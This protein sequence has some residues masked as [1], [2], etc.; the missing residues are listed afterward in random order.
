MPNTSTCTRCA[1][2]EKPLLSLWLEGKKQYLSPSIFDAPAG[3]HYT[4]S[5]MNAKPLLPD[6]SYW[7]L[8]RCARPVCTPDQ[9]DELARMAA[10][11]QDWDAL[12]AR[13]EAEGMAPL[14]VAHLSAADVGVPRPVWRQVRALALRH[15]TRNA[16]LMTALAEIVRAFAA[17][18][19]PLRV[20]K[21]AALAHLVYAEPG[22][23]PMSDLDLLVPPADLKRAGELLADLGFRCSQ[24][25]STEVSGHRH[26]APRLRIVD[27]VS[28][29]VELHHRLASTYSDWWLARLRTRLPH[30]LA[31][32]TN[33]AAL[34][35]EDGRSTG[36]DLAGDTA[37]T[38][39]LEKLLWH[40]CW[41][42]GSH[43][44]VWDSGRLIWVADV[45]G[46][47]ERYA[48]AIDWEEVRQNAPLVGRTLSV[49][50]HLT[51]LSPEVLER[52]GVEPGRRPQGVGQPFIGWP[53][54]SFREGLP[55]GRWRFVRETLAPSEWWLRL[56]YGL[57]SGQSLFW[58]RGVRHPLETG[59]R[60]LRAPLQRLGL[61]GSDELAWGS[62]GEM[63]LE[64]GDLNGR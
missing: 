26:L 36:F 59:A 54:V 44:N 24:G 51:P 55:G 41:H 43:V 16:A 35:G 11:F 39:S 52:A 29:L 1:A 9:L 18:N 17:A 34:D 8:A 15:R 23:R 7:L 42:L 14:L 64:Q 5:L 21:G 63:Q 40:L 19:L 56:H 37:Q 3:L 50:L 25:L 46:V 12:P 22:H 2:A 4:P 62:A 53:R 32:R 28:V 13:A 33:P 61:P 57:G 6:P 27:G 10:G 49:L 48:D 20:L 45:V 60:L 38:L 30:W 58:A 47:V 31:S